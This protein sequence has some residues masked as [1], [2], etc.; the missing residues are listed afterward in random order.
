MIPLRWNSNHYPKVQG[1]I[2]RITDIKKTTYGYL[3]KTF[4]DYITT[5]SIK[6]TV[7]TNGFTKAVVTVDQNYR[8]KFTC[9]YFF[10]NE[11]KEII[12][13][14]SD[15]TDTT[16]AEKKLWLKMQKDLVV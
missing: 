5:K 7:L 15:G 3:I 8:P 9:T 10:D 13:L 11:G 12:I 2:D 4:N 14:N 16:R 1:N 6:L